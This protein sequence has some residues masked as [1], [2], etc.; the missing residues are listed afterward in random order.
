[1]NDSFP[2]APEGWNKTLSDL[3][4]ELKR[5][6]RQ[7]VGNPE[8][9]WAR[10]YTRSQIPATMRFPKKGDVYEVLEDMT[11]TYLV[12]YTAPVTGRG[13]G[14]LKKGDRLI[15]DHEP[16]DA[17]PIGVYVKGVNHKDLE[18]RIVPRSIRRE[19]KYG[20]IYFFFDTVELNSKFK[21]AHHEGPVGSMWPERGRP[22]GQIN[23]A[24]SFI[25]G[26]SKVESANIHSAG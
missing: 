4:E 18:A 20:G 23:P 11:V 5:G 21:L 22:T 6:E 1:M 19:P 26:E 13:S 8:L 9:H 14:L 10:E 2:P 24:N 17:K 16:A 7:S 12:A 15:V 25:Y 3:H